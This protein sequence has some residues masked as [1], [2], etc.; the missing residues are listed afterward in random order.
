MAVVNL[1]GSLNSK[2]LTTIDTQYESLTI[3]AGGYVSLAKDGL[4]LNN[5]KMATIYYFSAI[6]PKTAI[7]VYANG[8]NAYLFGTPGTT[9]KNLM[10]R[11][12]K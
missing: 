4:E 2:A 9:V 10:I 8:K 12:W 3:P 7:T 11:Y 1:H 5:I 6:E